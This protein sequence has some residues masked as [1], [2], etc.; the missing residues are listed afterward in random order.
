MKIKVLAPLFALA[1]LAACAPQTIIANNRQAVIESWT[2]SD[3]VAMA[4][5]ECGARGRWPTLQRQSGSEYWFVCNETEEAIAARRKAAE[6]AALKRAEEM[7]KAM[8][9]VSP[10]PAVAAPA[11]V[12]PVQESRPAVAPKPAA[13][14]GYWVQV[15]AFKNR[16]VGE[17]FLAAIRRA[18]A[19]TVKG[20]DLIL[21]EAKLSGR[22]TLHLAR[23][24]PYPRS[25]AARR[26]CNAIKAGGAACFVIRQ[27]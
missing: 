18:H 23:L 2:A 16:Q 6:E 7:K 25:G 22:G 9:P 15:G 19:R 5:K 10:P 3:A 20:H 13:Q 21:R 11:A 17:R 14:K 27:R 8:A 24:G 26:A 12:A 4:E 1:A